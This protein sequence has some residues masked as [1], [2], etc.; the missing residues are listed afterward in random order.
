MELQVQLMAPLILMF[1]E[2]AEWLGQLV[3]AHHAG[4]HVEAPMSWDWLTVAVFACPCCM[5][6]GGGSLIEAAVLLANEET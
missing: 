4:P 5:R 6:N 1:A 3:S 2:A